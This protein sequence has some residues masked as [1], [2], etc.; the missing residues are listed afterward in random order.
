MNEDPQKRNELIIK[1]TC[2]LAM[3]FNVIIV[4]LTTVNI[5]RIFKDKR[6]N[7]ALVILFYTFAIFNTLAN[8]VTLTLVIF[9]PEIAAQHNEEI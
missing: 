3:S 5:F 6:M 8:L 4:F 7:N 2:L 1:G 9:E